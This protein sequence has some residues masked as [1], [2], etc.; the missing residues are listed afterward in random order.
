MRHVIKQIGERLI[1]SSRGIEPSTPEIEG[2]VQK[3]EL[4]SFKAI[5]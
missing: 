2:R 1:K 5:L 4:E 3:E